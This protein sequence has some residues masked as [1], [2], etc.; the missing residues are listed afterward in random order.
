MGMTSEGGI[1]EK[2]GM[3]GRSNLGK[4]KKEEIR[5][6]PRRMRRRKRRRKRRRE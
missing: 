6:R 2:G 4:E 1:K 5:R 3:L